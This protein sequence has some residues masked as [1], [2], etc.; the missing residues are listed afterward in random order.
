MISACPGQRY[1]AARKCCPFQ[2]SRGSR[3]S[4][5][6]RTPGSRRGPSSSP[7]YALLT[8]RER[9]RRRAYQASAEEVSEQST[10]AG[11]FT[12]IRLALAS[13]S[14]ASC[15]R[16]VASFALLTWDMTANCLPS[17]TPSAKRRAAWFK[18]SRWTVSSVLR[19]C[20]R[21]VYGCRCRPIGRHGKEEQ[22]LALHVFVHVRRARA[23]DS[24]PLDAPR[25]GLRP[26]GPP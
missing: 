20:H 4:P 12:S 25:Q 6:E 10:S 17:M 15:S 21:R 7:P 23:R 14:S 11:M 2:R 18:F 5:Q 19:P 16:T 1:T 13:P 3:R 26:C 9:P 22:Y 24:P 8:A